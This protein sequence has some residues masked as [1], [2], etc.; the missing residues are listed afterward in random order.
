MPDF[1]VGCHL[2]DLKDVF[3][4]TETE[5]FEFKVL[6]TESQ[7]C[8]GYCEKKHWQKNVH[9]KVKVRWKS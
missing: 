9:V 1:G 2:V 3:W 8:E 7:K 5:T 6:K 4:N